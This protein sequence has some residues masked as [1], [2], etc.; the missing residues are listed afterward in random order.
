MAKC[1]AFDRRLMAKDWEMAAYA[2]NHYRLAFDQEGGWGMKYNLIWDKLLGLHLFPERVLRKEVDFYL[3][4]MNEFGCPLDSRHNY[5]K[6]D[7]TVWT[8]SLAADRMTF[9]KFILPLHRFMN[10]TTDRV[11][12]AD[13]INT[14]RAT[15]AGFCGRSVVGAYFIGLIHE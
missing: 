3:T 8:A 12:M 15:V 9:R 4:R 11:P 13:L 7:W 10:E 2:G 1:Y 14:D 5:T 6:A